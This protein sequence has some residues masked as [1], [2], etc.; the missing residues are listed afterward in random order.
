MQKLSATAQKWYEHGQELV[1]PNTANTRIWRQGTGEPVVLLHGV[2]SSAYLYRKVLPE[3][4]K[5]GL[6]GIALDF[7]G[8]GFSERPS[9]FDYS[10]TG[11]SAWLEQAINATELDNFHLVVHDIGG[12]IGFDLIRRIPERI[13]SLTVLN[14][15]THVES[16]QKPWVMA[17]FEIPVLRD[18]WLLQM[19]TSGIFPFFRWQGVLSGSSYAEIRAYGELLRITDKGQ[20]FLKIMSRFDTNAEFEARILDAL[21]NRQFPAQVVWGRHDT[22]LTID[23]KAIDA[24]KALNLQSIHAIDG[25]HFLQENSYVEIA[26]RVKQLVDTGADI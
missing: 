1:I 13:K 2:P 6:E 20:G 15:I 17:P 16:F 23:T 21:A 26:E 5:R 7:P 9:D 8:L 4:A 24:Q 19:D 18:L 10:W 22:A 12:P 14:T 3:L 11:L 25:K